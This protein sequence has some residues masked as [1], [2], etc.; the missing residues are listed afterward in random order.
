MQVTKTEKEFINMWNAAEGLLNS[1]EKMELLFLL[2]L[3]EIKQ[4][5]KPIV[6][7]LQEVEKLFRKA[8]VERSQKLAKKQLELCVKN[9]H[10]EPMSVNGEL[11]L[12]EENQTQYNNF[13]A[14]LDKKYE[15]EKKLSDEYAESISKTEVTVELPELPTELLPKKLYGQQLESLFCL[16]KHKRNKA[17]E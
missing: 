6:E 7:K 16:I 11:Y 3:A 8:M 17:S 4:E 14:E 15:K 10:G 2:T 13:S 1:K 12:T 5:L 9:P